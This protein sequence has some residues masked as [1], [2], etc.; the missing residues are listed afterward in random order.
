[1]KAETLPADM[2]RMGLIYREYSRVR[3]AELHAKTR[4]PNESDIVKQII[5]EW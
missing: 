3:Y 1:M 5:E 4:R 2:R